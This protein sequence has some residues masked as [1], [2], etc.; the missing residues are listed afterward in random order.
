MHIS[1]TKSTLR[2]LKALEEIG[3]DVFHVDIELLGINRSE[4]GTMLPPNGN[5]HSYTA[6]TVVNIS[7]YAAVARYGS[8]A[9]FSAR[10]RLIETEELGG[11][12][13]WLPV[14]A[15][16]TVVTDC[17]RREIWHWGSDRQPVR[18]R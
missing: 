2:A 11:W 13:G 10:I 1:L 12:F 3:L 17:A 8:N 18:R 15:S 14:E 7:G 16:L 9:D 5:W 4:G 6:T